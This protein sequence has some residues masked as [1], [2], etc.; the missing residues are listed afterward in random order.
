M[1]AQVTIDTGDITLYLSPGEGGK[2]AI[3][4]DHLLQNLYI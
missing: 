4:L 2:G 3:R 1:F